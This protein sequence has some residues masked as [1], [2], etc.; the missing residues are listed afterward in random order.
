[1]QRHFIVVKK[2]AT[3]FSGAFLDSCICM[4]F[5]SLVSQTTG[6][7]KITRIFVQQVNGLRVEV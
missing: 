7:N 4:V 1:M 6:L 3:Y 2:L 5:K